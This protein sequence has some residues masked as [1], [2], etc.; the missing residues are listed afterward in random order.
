MAPYREAPELRSNEKRHRRTAELPYSSGDTKGK[1][2]TLS[3]VY[4]YRL[5]LEHGSALQHKSSAMTKF[6]IKRAKSRSFV[7]K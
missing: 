5:Q 1:C 6:K 3:A 2:H 4:V 7:T